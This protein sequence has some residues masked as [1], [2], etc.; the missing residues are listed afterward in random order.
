MIKVKKEKR[1][2][3]FI[4][5][6]FGLSPAYASLGGGMLRR[7][8][9]RISHIIQ[10]PYVRKTLLPHL[11][12]YAIIKHLSLVLRNLRLNVSKI[13]FIHIS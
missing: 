12:V 13:I 10:Q 9:S 6:N 8:I 5:N 3:Y 2:F 11:P 1:I 7:R 4:P